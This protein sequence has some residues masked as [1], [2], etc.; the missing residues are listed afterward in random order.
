MGGGEPLPGAVG[1]Q[2]LLDGAPG[3]RQH[4]QALGVNFDVLARV[5]GLKLGRIIIDPGHGGHDYGA[6]GPGGCTVHRTGGS[7]GGGC[8]RGTRVA[9]ACTEVLGATW[10]DDT[11]TWS[12]RVRSTGGDGASHQ[13]CED[14]AITRALPLLKKYQY[15]ATLAVVGY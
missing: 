4:A 1:A 6:S 15:P 5:L 7:G 3:H 2:L 13:A 9:C 11:Q 14:I 8:T 12:V 10:S